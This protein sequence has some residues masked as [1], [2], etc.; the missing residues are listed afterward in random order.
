MKI[1]PLRLL[2]TDARIRA[3]AKET[4]QTVAAREGWL[5]SDLRLQGVTAT[6]L[7]VLYR[8]HLR[9]TDPTHCFILNFNNPTY[10]SC[11]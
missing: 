7:T 8:E 6:T 9:G 5:L 2:F 4:M 3:Q 1:L 11:D 10:Q